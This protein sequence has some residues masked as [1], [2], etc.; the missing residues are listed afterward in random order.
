MYDDDPGRELDYKPPS[1]LKRRGFIVAIILVVILAAGGGFWALN[2]LR[3]DDESAAGTGPENDPEEGDIPLLGTDLAEVLP[4]ERREH[5]SNSDREQSDLAWSFDPFADPLN[6]TGVIS[7][8]RGGSMAII[9]SGSASHVV[10]AGDYVNGVWSVRR[11]E[12][13]RAV[14]RARDR[15]ITIFLE[16]PPQVRRLD[17]MD[18]EESDHL[19]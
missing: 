3:G 11:V 12:E 10:S 5:G 8:G 15:E 7:G 13:D 4:Q 1:L 18:E 17:L 2:L 6:I 19:R 14:L 16:G 9:E